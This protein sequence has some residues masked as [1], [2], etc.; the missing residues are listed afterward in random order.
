[1]R[2]FSDR[3]L[4]FALSVAVYK[5]LGCKLPFYSGFGSFLPSC[6]FMSDPVCP[7]FLYFTSFSLFNVFFLS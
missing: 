2:L 1:M 7:H 5:V 6:C 3:L 4:S